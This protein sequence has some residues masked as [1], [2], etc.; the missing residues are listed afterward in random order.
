VK[1]GGGRGEFA[2]GDDGIAN[3]RTTSD[4]SV[5]QLA[6]E[7]TVVE[8]KAINQRLVFRSMFR[9]ADSSIHSRDGIKR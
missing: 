5:E 7:G 8:T 9:E 2:E 1:I 4:V 6:E 3:V